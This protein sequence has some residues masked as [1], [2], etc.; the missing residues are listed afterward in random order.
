[1][2]QVVHFGLTTYRLPNASTSL[3]AELGTVSM[4][5]YKIQI[6]RQG[7]SEYFTFLEHAADAA[8]K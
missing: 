7:Y 6:H 1:M 4:T 2:H 5:E 8:E 3:H